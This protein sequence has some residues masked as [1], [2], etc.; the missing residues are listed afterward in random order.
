MEAK[1]NFENVSDEQLAKEISARVAEL[2]A[3]HAKRQKA[4]DE[5]YQQTMQN[6]FSVKDAPKKRGRKPHTVTS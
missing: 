6:A 4:L 1:V 3:R 5:T 2:K